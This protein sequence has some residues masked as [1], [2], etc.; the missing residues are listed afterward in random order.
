MNSR[1]LYRFLEV[2]TRIFL[3]RQRVQALLVR[4]RLARV[5]AVGVAIRRTHGI[6]RKDDIRGRG[7]GGVGGRF[8]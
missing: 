6:E 2:F 3:L 5:G 7:G 8:G 1:T 4:R